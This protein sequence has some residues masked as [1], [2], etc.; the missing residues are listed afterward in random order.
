LDNPVFDLMLPLLDRGFVPYSLGWL[1]GLRRLWSL[2]PLA[3]VVLAALSLV[4][5]GQAGDLRRRAPHA[6]PAAA[7]PA[8]PLLP[9]RPARRAR[10]QRRG[11]AA[12]VPP[13]EGGGEP[14]V[15]ARR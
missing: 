10:K 8:A 4:V 15:P 12:A 2:A 5:G 3:L 11:E 7:G 13:A 14:P 6:G 9:A 1:L